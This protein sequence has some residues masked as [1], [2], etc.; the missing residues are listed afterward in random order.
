MA[1]TCATFPEELAQVR[2]IVGDMP[3]LVPGIG[4]QGGDIAATV[5]SGKTA[6]GAGMMINSSRAILYAEPQGGEDYAQA[7]R[8][9]ARE[10]RDAINAYRG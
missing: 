9:V 5:R 7:A 8:R 6:A 3:L 10:T 2:A 1:R 4:A